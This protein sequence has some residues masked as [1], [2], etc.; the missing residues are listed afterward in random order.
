MTSILVPLTLALAC[1]ADTHSSFAVVGENPVDL[2]DRGRLVVEVEDE[3]DRAEPGHPRALPVRVVVTAID[4]THPDGS[5]RGTYSDGRFFVQGQFGVDVPPGRTRVALGSGPNYEPLELEADVKS[6]RETRLRVRLHCWFAPE[7]RGWYGGDNHVHAQHDATVAVRT[8]L[9]YTALQGRADGLS[10]VTEADGGPLSAEVERLSTPTFLFRRVPELR[11]GPFV[12]H[13][14]TPGIGQPIPADVF[15]RLVAGPLPVERIVEE[16][17]RRGGVVTHTHP[18]TPPYQWHWMGAAEVLSDAVLGHTTDALDLD[19]PASE[20]LWFAV[21]NLGNRVACSS[22]TDCALG[23][24]ST[25]S[26]GDRRVYCRAAGLTYAG[27]VEAIRRGRTFATNGGPV[28]AFFTIDGQGPGESLQPGAGAHRLRAEIHSLHPLKL[29]RFYR[30]GEELEAIEVRGRRG[31]V[32][33]ETSRREAPGEWAWYVLRT[34]D[35]KGNWAITS[36]IRVGSTQAEPRPFASAMILEINNTARFVELRRAF[37]AHIV[38]TVSPGER[39]ESVELRKDGRVVRRFAP[40]GGDH[41]AAG[42]VPVTGLGGEYEPG[43]VW[44][45]GPDAPDHLQAD[46][47]VAETGWYSL[48]AST[49]GGKTLASEAIFFDAGSR[50]S[51]ALTVAQLEGPGTRFE[52]RGYGEEMPLEQ[53]RAP[54]EGD[55]WWYPQRTYWHIRALFGHS[56]RDLSRGDRQAEALFRPAEP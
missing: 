3:D 5:G 27:V 50:M 9:Q 45:P 35:E 20:L 43:W 47:P 14:N 15:S 30:Q 17:H 11:P 7:E 54:F 40:A 46:W 26:P 16:V 42:K 32:I 31:E 25:L 36:P 6:G 29:A 48:R 52:H 49:A 2:K 10:F 19:G 28:F 39:L 33:V 8:D 13:L 4:G 37:F 55:H 53:I 1:F 22:Y 56:R 18:L 41:L 23:R 44:H 12:G 34:E 24:K 21:L 38:V 51:R